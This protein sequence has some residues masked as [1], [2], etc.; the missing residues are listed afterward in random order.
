MPHATEVQHAERAAFGASVRRLREAI[1][2][3]RGRKL[4]QEGLAHRAELE[5]SYIGQIESGKRNVTLDNIHRLARA[6]GVHPAELF[7]EDR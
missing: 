3:E 6:L 2:D 5:R 4:T 1:T 7:G